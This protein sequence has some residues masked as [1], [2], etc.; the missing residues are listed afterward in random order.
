MSSEPILIVWWRRS[1]ITSPE[2]ICLFSKLHR[3]FA[4][5]IMQMFI[6]IKKA[7]SVDFDSRYTM[8]TFKLIQQ[9]VDKYINDPQGGSIGCGCG[10]RNRIQYSIFKLHPHIDLC[11]RASYIILPKEKE[12]SQVALYQDVY[13]SCIYVMAA[14][15]SAGSLIPICTD[16]LQSDVGQAWA[17]YTQLRVAEPSQLTF[18]V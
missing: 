18:F 17:S 10:I 11:Y 3:D 8:F 5:R 16:R 14:V 2:Y 1:R 12:N 6:A 13:R 15:K 7:V 9:W 4:D